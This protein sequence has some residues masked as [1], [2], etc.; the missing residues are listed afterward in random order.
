MPEQ[1]HP[2]PDPL[3][4]SHRITVYKFITFEV[5]MF[6]MSLYGMYE[7]AAK[8]L[9]FLN[10]SPAPEMVLKPSPDRPHHQP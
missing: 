2:G 6:A 3:A 10:P 8:K 7:L 9:P 4:I 5:F 1:S